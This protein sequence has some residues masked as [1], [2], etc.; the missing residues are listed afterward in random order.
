MVDHALTIAPRNARAY[1]AKSQILA[2]SNELDYR[3]QIDEAIDAAE[4]AI[5]LDHNLAGAYNWIGRLQA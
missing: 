4:T 1:L 2:Y 5:S 3:G